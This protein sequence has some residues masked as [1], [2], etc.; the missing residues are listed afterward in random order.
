MKH[1]A[2]GARAM[3]EKEGWAKRALRRLMG[4]AV[5][6]SVL[7]MA[8][9]VYAVVVHREAM[10][11]LPEMVGNFEQ[12]RSILENAAPR[13]EFTFLVAGDTRGANGIIENFLDAVKDVKPDFA[14]FLGDIFNATDM[15]E[16]YFRAECVGEM[17]MPFPI[18]LV[19]GNE[20]IYPDNFTLAQ[21]EE[22]YGPTVFSFEYQDCLFVF[23]CATGDPDGDEASMALLE[24]LIADD[25]SRYRKR[26]VFMHIP[27]KMDAPETH[28]LAAPEEFVTLFERLGADHVFAGHYHGYEQIER[29]GVDY[30]VT[31]G[32]GASLDRKSKF[33]QFHHGMLVTVGKDYVG[34]QI[35]L[36]S[37]Q[38]AFEDELERFAICNVYPWMSASPI[39][40]YG[41]DALIVAGLVGLAVRRSRT[42]RGAA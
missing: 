4:A 15:T 14:V 1:I 31:G 19:V 38:Y 25:P 34:K 24:K 9:Q 42:R 21:F 37:R 32:G 26:F 13:D 36:T 16:P 18:F 8:L 2:G 28:K 39:V 40:A 10:M 6:A 5:I 11:P 41:I 23:L 29:G 20:D 7:F 27:P 30:V 22:T 35:I 12:T 33:D 3:H 17:A